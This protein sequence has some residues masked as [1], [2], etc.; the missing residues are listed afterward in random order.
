MNA[1]HFSNAASVIMNAVYGIRVAEGEDKYILVAEKAL[2]GMAKAAQPG[3]FLVD[4]IPWRT[5]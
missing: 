4:L 2:E 1:R 5:S 3:A